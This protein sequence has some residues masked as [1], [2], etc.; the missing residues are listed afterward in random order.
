MR[1]YF[2]D[3]HR[4]CATSTD[5]VILFISLGAISTITVGL[6]KSAKLRLYSTYSMCYYDKYSAL[7]L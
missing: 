3:L 2:S 7:I 4:N 5:K 6:L 1:I